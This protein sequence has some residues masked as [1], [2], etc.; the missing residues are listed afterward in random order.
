M[1][2][3]HLELLLSKR[4]L[5]ATGQPVGRIEEVRGEPQGDEAVVK[6][7]LLGPYGLLE[8]LSAWVVGNTVLRLFWARKVG[9]RYHVPW[10]AMDLT[11]PEQPRLRCTKQEL[12]VMET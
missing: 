8:R 12:E 7:Y 10:D 1:A 2:Q 9:S 4:V 5:D 3:I 11:D 6:A